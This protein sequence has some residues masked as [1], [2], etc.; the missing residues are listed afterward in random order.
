MK[1]TKLL[2]MGLMALAF[3]LASHAQSTFRVATGATGGTYLPIGEIIAAALNQPGKLVVSAQTA[4]GSVA[5]VN[6]V[7]RGTVES[8][9]AQADIATWAY[10]GSMMFDGKPRQT[11]LRL[12]SNLYPEVIHVMVKKDSGIRSIADLKGKRVS[13]DVPG[14]GT[15]V[16]ALMVLK[17]Y[18]VKESEIFPEFIK[19]YQAVDKLQDGEIDAFFFVGGA[20]A[21]TITELAASDTKIA[22]LPIDGEPANHLR[23]LSPYLTPTT[24]P[25]GT[26]P[27]VATVKTLAVGAQWVTSAA[28]DTE[29]VY[30]LTKA[31]F[32]EPTQ[33]ALQAGHPRGKL[34]RLETATVGAG[35]PLHPGAEKFYKEVGLMK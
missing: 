10:Q 28:A 35:I 4:S 32:S 30:Q 8:S 11:K 16:N 25:E 5:N 20:P 31:L 13:I 7:S 21:G 24:L 9:F 15:L 29:V 2:A 27:G 1:L 26:Y 17:A 14:S 19:T 33:R 23:E 6:D 18:G 12:I 3:P 22:L 34:I